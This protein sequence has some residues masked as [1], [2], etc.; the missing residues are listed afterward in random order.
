[1]LFYS[2]EC[3]RVQGGSSQEDELQKER[4]RASFMK[5]T[6]EEMSLCKRACGEN[7]IYAFLRKDG[8]NRSLATFLTAVNCHAVPGYGPSGGS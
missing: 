4:N 1:M 8:E 2:L 5:E 3:S 6:T 7:E